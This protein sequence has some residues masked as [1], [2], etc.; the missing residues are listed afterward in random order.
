VSEVRQST[1]LCGFAFYQ[2]WTAT[3][4]GLAVT[5]ETAIVSEVW[6]F[7]APNAGDSI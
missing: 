7:I 5:A 3:L 2:G 4:F 6:Q 1:K